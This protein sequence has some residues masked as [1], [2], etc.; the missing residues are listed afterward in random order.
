MPY[1]IF[2]I[3]TV[4]YVRKQNSSVVKMQGISTIRDYDSD[5]YILVFTV[6]FMRLYWS[7]CG[8]KR[9]M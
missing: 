1:V 2:D 8:F 4:H 5:V 3:A 9:L 6:L 7:D